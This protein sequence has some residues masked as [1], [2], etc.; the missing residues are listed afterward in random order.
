MIRVLMVDDHAV[1]RRGLRQILEETRDMQVADE[2]CDGGEAVSKVEERNYDVVIL[3]ICLPGRNGLEVLKEIRRRRPRLPVLVLTVYPA[4]QYAVRALRAGAAGYLTKTSVPE[5][6]V[7]AI[8]KVVAGGKYVSSALAEELVT[9]ISAG[10]S[11][12]PHD[13]LSDR[14][15]EIMLMIAGGT[16][17]T[18]IGH[19]LSLSPKTVSTYRRRI[20]DKMNLRSNSHLTQYVI[21]RGLDSPEKRPAS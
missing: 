13:Q 14:E 15:F 5:E 19:G 2:A 11:N 9:Q 21:A 4:D 17:I 16:T 7:S 10:G 12:T 1:V 6:L 18:E 20:L 8:R 3:D